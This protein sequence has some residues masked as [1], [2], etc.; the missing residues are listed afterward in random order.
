[1]KSRKARKKEREW[2]ERYIEEEYKERKRK[3]GWARKEREL[4]ERNTRKRKKGEKEKLRKAR[5][6]E[7]ERG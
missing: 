4:Q 3:I 6:K 2:S 1:M 7:R 5:K